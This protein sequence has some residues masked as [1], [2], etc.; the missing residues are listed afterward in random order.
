MIEG[1]EILVLPNLALYSG[2]KWSCR[3]FQVAENYRRV[4]PAMYGLTV[5]LAFL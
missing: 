1:Y 2:L 4:L 5:A 3:A